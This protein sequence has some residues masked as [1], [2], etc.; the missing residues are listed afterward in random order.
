[1]PEEYS[2]IIHN[3]NKTFLDNRQKEIHAI[4]GLN[5]KVKKGDFI[6][7]VGENGS[8]KST[9]MKIILGSIDPDPGSEVIC[10]GTVVRLALGMNFEEN[11]SA[12]DNILFNGIIMGIS[13]NYLKS[14]MDRIL[15]FAGLSE[16][17]MTLVKYF[18]T[19]MKARLSISI[20][21]EAKADIYLIDESF[22]EV[23][24][25]RFREKAHQVMM[26]R[27]SEGKTILHVTHSED[28]IRQY[29]NKVLELENGRGQLKNLLF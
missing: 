11:L 18:S 17:G 10:N 9:L 1:M 25:Q 19:G 23:G 29:C 4:K 6:G 3:L 2:I 20:A 27:L 21:L 15:E 13:E 8:G 5:L 16:Y 28:L 12:V 7:V 14:S 26:E 24:D 22:A